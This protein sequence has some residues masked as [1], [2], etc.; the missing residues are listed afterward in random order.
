ME[1][2][3]GGGLF[4]LAGEQKLGTRICPYQG[5]LLRLLLLIT[6]CCIST[7][8]AE[9]ERLLV[10]GTVTTASSEMEGRTAWP[11]F[12]ASAA[13]A[14]GYFSSATLSF[15]KIQII[16]WRA[17]LLERGATSNRHRFVTCETEA[18]SYSSISPHRENRDLE[19]LAP[20]IPAF[21]TPHKQVISA[22][23]QSGLLE[24]GL[25]S[26]RVQDT[27]VLSVSYKNKQWFKMPG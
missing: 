6:R 15:A 10:A 21:H 14:L 20:S 12:L 5:L 17:R 25:P 7:A 22:F 11:C 1:E 9:A 26:S 13:V 4:S 24:S 8:A 27:Q 3:P 18:R 16:K 2:G 19:F 23:E